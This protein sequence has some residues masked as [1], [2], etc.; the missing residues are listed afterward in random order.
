[1]ALIRGRRIARQTDARQVPL[2]QQAVDERARRL[3]NYTFS[4]SELPQPKLK[5]SKPPA[6]LSA[7]FAAPRQYHSLTPLITSTKDSS[8][9]LMTC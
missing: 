8:V 5:P 6:C 9:Y 1:M 4:W 7:A 3:P 2:S